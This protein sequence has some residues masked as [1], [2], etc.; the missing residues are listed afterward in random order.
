MPA[1]LHSNSNY[2]SNVYP[3]TLAIEVGFENDVLTGPARS[4]NP[5]FSQAHFE[6][7][8]KNFLT[9]AYSDVSLA[10]LNEATRAKEQGA[11]L[12]TIFNESVV[13]AKTFS[14]Q[15]TIIIDFQ[16]I[17]SK[18]LNLSDEKPKGFRA[19]F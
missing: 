16:T 18:P 8:A 11:N 13:P 14:S 7:I 3:R 17:E 12:S 1:M 6:T 15:V 5:Q 10:T 2:T 4:N 19:T 9:K